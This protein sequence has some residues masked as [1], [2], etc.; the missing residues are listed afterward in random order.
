M[1]AKVFA[2]IFIALIIIQFIILRIY[3]KSD[4]R[5]KGIGK[6]FSMN[7]KGWLYSILMWSVFGLIVFII[8]LIQN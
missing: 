3:T 5:I 2:W 8:S 4:K 7:I 1:L 6:P